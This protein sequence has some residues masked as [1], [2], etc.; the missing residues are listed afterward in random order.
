MTNLLESYIRILQFQYNAIAYSDYK[1]FTESIKELNLSTEMNEKLFQR[2]PSPECVAPANLDNKFDTEWAEAYATDPQNPGPLADYQ[3]H[4]WMDKED[5]DLYRENDQYKEIQKRS[6]IK[7]FQVLDDIRENTIH[8]LGRCNNPKDWG[9]KNNQGLVYGMVQSG[10]T[11]SMINLISMGIIAGYKLFIILAGDKDSLRKQTQKRVNKAFQLE[12]GINSEEKI[13]SPTWQNDFSHTGLEYSGTFKTEKIIRGQQYINIIVIKKETHHLNH[14][15]E[16]IK[17]LNE[18]SEMHDSI[19]SLKENLPTLIFDDEADSA[20]INTNSSGTDPTTINKDLI[21]L[22]NSIPRNCYAA[23]TATPQACLGADPRK[24]IGYPNDFFWLIEP[25]SEE[26]NG[27]DVTRTYL[28]A[29]DVFHQYDEYLVEKIGRNEWPHYEKDDLGRLEG[30]WMPEKNGVEGR[31]L[32]DTE[33]TNDDA[34]KLFLEQIRDGER[35]VPPS[36]INSLTDFIIGAGVR[37]YDYWKNDKFENE[38]LP[39]ISDVSTNYPHHAIMI[40]LSRLLEHQLIAREIVEIAWE[41]VL[42]NWKNFDID[43]P[44]KENPFHERWNYQRYRTS[45]LKKTRGNLP[46]TKIEYFMNLA[47]KIAELPIREDRAPYNEYD[48][49]PYIYL[50]NSDDSGM[51]LYYDEDDPWEIKTKRATI[52][53]GGQI[54]SRGL[55]IE[56][57]SV[58]FFGRT[59]QMPMGDSVLQMGRW[60]G[61]KKPYLDLI[62]IYVQE[63]MRILFRDIADADR[64]LRIQIKDAIFRDLKPNEILLELRN[65][66]Q[67]RATSPAKSQFVNY[68]NSKSYSGRKALLREPTFSKDSIIKNNELIKQFELKYRTRKEEMHNRAHIYREIPASTVINLLRKLSCK[69][70]ATQDSFS[71]YARYLEDWIDDEKLPQIPKINIAIMKNRL[72]RRKRESSI[73]KPKTSEEARGTITGRFSSIVGGKSSNGKYLGDH[74]LDKNEEWHEKANSDEKYIRKYS[75]D[76]ILIVLYG[77]NPNYVTKKLFNQNDVDEE[78]PLGKWR[79]EIVELQEGDRYYI[80]IPEGKEIKYSVLVFAGFTPRGGPQ[81]NLGVNSLLDPVKIKQK[82]LT[83]LY[84]ENLDGDENE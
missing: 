20:S 19:F 44:T 2:F 38:S 43:L 56:G 23:Y 26:K 50:I 35:K 53:V 21:N 32:E 73:S 71:D 77:L 4:G 60:F 1:Q 58:S 80:D 69:N 57:L 78:N 27:Q 59:A 40:H 28:G 61:H 37:W 6:G 55:T 72:M 68:Q 15:I 13:H 54:L 64:Y 52:I 16:Q 11:A 75:R 17:R 84:E 5:I 18:F 10:K 74:L 39:S 70:T 8:I 46:F 33:G 24:I 76:D 25:F 49:S 30:I 65:S 29:Y 67:F 31:I 36:L 79:N 7:D 63:G 42:N 34:Q 12:N 66:P 51:R 45:R 14:L 9:E 48:G 47:I 3:N 41:E 83:F 82:G 62:N 22:R 81:Y